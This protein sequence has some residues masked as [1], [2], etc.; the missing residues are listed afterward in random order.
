MNNVKEYFTEA[1]KN[2][3]NGYLIAALSDEYIVDKWPSDRMQ[4]IIEREYLVLELRVFNPD[5]ELKLSRGNIGSEFKYR[6]LPNENTKDMDTFDEIQYLDIDDT[7]SLQDGK[8]QT[9]GGGQY[10]LPLNNKKNAKIKIR[11]YVGKYET[12]GQARV[13]DWRVVEFVEGE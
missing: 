1:E 10:N 13:E 8:V 11:Y 4:E 2:I 12:T 6:M 5:C 7:V 9:T 3:L